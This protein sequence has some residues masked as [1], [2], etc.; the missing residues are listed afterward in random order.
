MLAKSFTVILPQ[1]PRNIGLSA[2]TTVLVR[3][4]VEVSHRW[5]HAAWHLKDWP[6]SLCM[7]WFQIKPI[8]IKPRNFHHQEWPLIENS[9]QPV[10]HRC[11]F[12]FSYSLQVQVSFRSIMLATRN[13]IIILRCTQK[14]QSR[15]YEQLRAC[16]TST[17]S[18]QPGIAMNDCSDQSPCPHSV[19]AAMRNV[20]MDPSGI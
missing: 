6:S 8:S 2:S 4:T 18:V 13:G 9:W 10:S 19:T 1:H 3:R 12:R 20:Y 17:L 11:T 15:I 16:S 14:E 7:G 5:I